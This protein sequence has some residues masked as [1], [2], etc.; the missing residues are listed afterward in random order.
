MPTD[1]RE[2]GLERL[3]VAAMTFDTTV[4]QAR[5]TRAAT[6]S[7][8]MEAVAGSG[9]PARLQPRVRGRSCFR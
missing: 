8:F 3:I 4:A 9:R 6:P 1:T 7:R 5:Q 2:Y